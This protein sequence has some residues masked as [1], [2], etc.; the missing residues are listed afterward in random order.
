MDLGTM[1][2]RIEGRYYQELT[3]YL[4]DLTLMCNNCME[5]NT[6]DTPF[7]KIG[8]KMLTACEKIFKREKKAAAAEA[9]KLLD[10]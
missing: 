4:D 2:E 7:H 6:P 9:R 5:Y 1:K 3:E 8:K 10:E